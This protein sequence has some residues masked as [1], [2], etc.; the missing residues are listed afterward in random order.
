MMETGSVSWMMIVGIYSVLNWPRS[1][2][3]MYDGLRCYA[4]V[5]ERSIGCEQKYAFKECRRSI[6]CHKK[7]FAYQT[8]IFG[9]GSILL[10]LQS[11]A[12]LLDTSAETCAYALVYGV[13][14]LTAQ[15]CYTAALAEGKVAICSAIYSM[16]RPSIAWTTLTKPSKKLLLMKI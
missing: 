11:G 1:S 12:S 6:L 5:V 14:L 3:E 9:A 4:S 2:R 10:L 8:I 15:W 7:F 16:P 13:M